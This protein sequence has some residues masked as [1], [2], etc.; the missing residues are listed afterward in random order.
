MRLH[1]RNTYTMDTN[2]TSAQHDTDENK[3]SKRRPFL[4]IRRLRPQEMPGLIPRI[5]QNRQVQSID[6]PNMRKIS[7]SVSEAMMCPNEN[8]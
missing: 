2:D 1:P 5:S 4:I 3:M 6:V 7:S 8:R